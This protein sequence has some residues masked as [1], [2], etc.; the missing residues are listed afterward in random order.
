MTYTPI[1]GMDWTYDEIYLPGMQDPVE[2]GIDIIEVDMDD[3]PYLT[4]EAKRE[5][6]KGYSE[7]EVTARKKGRYVQLGGNVF[8]EFSAAHVIG[9]ADLAELWNGSLYP[10]SDWLLYW[11]LDHGLNAPTAIYWHAVGPDGSVITFHEIYQNETL[12]VDFARMVNDY[13]GKELRRTPDFRTGDPAIK[14]RSG[15]T[16]TSIFQAYAEHGIYIAVDSVPKDGSIGITKMRQHMRTNRRTGRPFWQIAN[17]P[18]LVKELERLHWKTFTSL[19]VRD[20]NN[21]ME[22]VHKK[23]DHGFD[24]CKYFFTFM[25][26]LKPEETEMVKVSDFSPDSLVGAMNRDHGPVP[27]PAIPWKIRSADTYDELG[28]EGDE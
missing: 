28:L 21:P 1:F 23:N 9:D 4:E 18:S 16:G 19:K 10:P 22:Q 24:S 8:K 26:D 13:E 2:S 7:D 14:Q 20:D 6:L 27:G 15:I 17:C 5:V 11:S 3:N 25:P 12:V